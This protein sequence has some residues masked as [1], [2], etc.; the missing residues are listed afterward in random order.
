MKRIRITVYLNPED[1]KLIE[2]YAEQAGRSVSDYLRRAG[3]SEGPRHLPKPKLLD[4]IDT[5]IEES[6]KRLF[7]T[8]DEGDGAKWWPTDRGGK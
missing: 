5:R 1:A 4:L 8:R 2:V 6:V 7:P 3:L